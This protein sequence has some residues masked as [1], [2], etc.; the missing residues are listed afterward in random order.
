MDK[1]ARIGMG[2]VIANAAGVQEADREEWGY[3]I[4]SGV[5][6][7]MRNATIPDGAVI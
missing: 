7:V 2:V 3:I 5:V 1:N 4:R 6:V